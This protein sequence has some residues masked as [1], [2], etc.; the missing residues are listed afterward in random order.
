[1]R[2]A[3][4]TLA[5][6][7]AVFVALAIPACRGEQSPPAVAWSPSGTDTPVRTATFEAGPSTPDPTVHNPAANDPRAVAD[8]R[9]LYAGFNYAGLGEHHGLWHHRNH[10]G[11]QRS[12]DAVLGGLVRLDHGGTESTEQWYGTPVAG[13]SVR[14]P[15]PTGR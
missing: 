6:P 13:L 15:P 7:S 3:R 9:A 4:R 12:S 1:M 10:A 5:I 8:G 11:H 2:V 14:S